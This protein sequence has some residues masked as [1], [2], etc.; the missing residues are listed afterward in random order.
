[1]AK[2]GEVDF[3][4]GATPYREW[5]KSSNNIYKSTISLF[6]NKDFSKDFN[7]KA[8]YLIGIIGNDLKDIAKNNFPNSEILEYRDYKALFKDFLSKKLDL[9]LDDKTGI[10]F[11]FTKKW[12]FS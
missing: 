11:F 6:I 12:F 4:L 10:E 1:M 8:P 9:I 5:M 2:K 3:F 7:L